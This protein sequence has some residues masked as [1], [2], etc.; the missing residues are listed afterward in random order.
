M[1][2]INSISFK[3][4]AKLN[5]ANVIQPITNTL[6]AAISKCADSFESITNKKAN[7]NA[8]LEKIL[9]AS[10]NPYSC[11][12]VWQQLSEKLH[13]I[14]EDNFPEYF[15]F[16]QNAFKDTGAQFTGRVK[17]SASIMPKLLKRS[18]RILVGNC[19]IADT[20][21]DLYGF[22]LVT[23]PGG[24]A[25]SIEKIVKRIESLVNSGELIPSHF[26]NHG[27]KPYFNDEQVERLVN[28]GFLHAG[29]IE[30]KTGF[31][32]VNLYFRDKFDTTTLEL[33]ITGDKTNLVN[34]KEHLFYNF[35]TKGAATEHGVVNK[36]LQKIFEAMDEDDIAAYND[37]INQCYLYSRAE[38]IGEKLKKP[39]LPEG[40][41]KVLSLI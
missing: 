23:T 36:E 25:A 37:Y 14:G 27:K 4:I 18:D 17:E 41:S 2:I 31:T 1:D 38:E 28:K 32:G 34:L 12:E 26:I 3:G 20:I 40:F 24:R 15:K 19:N 16:L 33:Q 9:Y 5:K 30:K 11:K 22:K 10:D 29:H 8:M 13:E 21:P 39:S 35:K 7:E 6:A